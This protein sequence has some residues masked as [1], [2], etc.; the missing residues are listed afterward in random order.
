MK[1][2]QK[3]MSGV[4]LLTWLLFLREHVKDS[5]SVGQMTASLL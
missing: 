1:L 2:L 4:L 3:C 5:V